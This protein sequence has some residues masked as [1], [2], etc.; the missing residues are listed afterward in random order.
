MAEHFSFFDSV[1]G[2]DG[3]TY[4]RE[5]DAQQFTDY[6]KTL[7]TTGVMKGAG[8]QLVLTANGQNMQTSM[9]T[10]IAFI[11]G[12]YYLNDAPLTFTHD[13]ETLG[14]N[15]IDRIVIRL[16]LNTEARNVKAFIKKGTAS[17]NPVP[18]VLIQN[19][20]VYEI[21][22]AQV[23]IVGGQTYIAA[24]A[25]TD[26]RGKEII[27]PWCGSKI[28][29]NFDNEAL[30]ELINNQLIDTKGL[31][32]VINEFDDKNIDNILKPGLYSG[33]FNS[34]SEVTGTLPFNSK[35]NFLMKVIKYTYNTNSV[36][37][38]VITR[39]YLT[40]LNTQKTQYR[41][42]NS[43]VGSWGNWLE[44]GMQ[45]INDSTATTTFYVDGTNGKDSPD[46]GGS[47]G[48]G[49][50]K[51]IQY[52]INQ[53]KK[54]NVGDVI[55]SVTDAVYNE[56]V[57]LNG[58]SGAKV[59]LKGTVTG[60][61]ANSV[62]VTN[63]DDIELGYLNT[64]KFVSFDNVKRAH[65]V[66]HK[67]TVTGEGSVCLV[68]NNTQCFVDSCTY[69]NSALAIRANLNSSVYVAGCDGSNNTMIYDAKGSVIRRGANTITGATQSTTSEGG[70][71]L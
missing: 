2:E 67:R 12:R 27:C 69:S 36:Q 59:F 58:F 61:T 26:E 45:N 1:I 57:T 17:A 60:F 14:L 46:K 44:D 30:S 64:K 50:F 8:N 63:C 71:V 54:L 40:S 43:T 34:S 48:T 21:S 56:D 55:I 70:Q 6:F 29:P 51:T 37:G 18:P 35:D 25:V 68:C 19:D 5:Y 62:S 28:L 7:V 24:N 49:A 53:V 23:R 31:F 10:G 15:R 66:Y 32:Y 39:Q 22:I 20:T 65:L 13:T 41:I 33:Y 47:A 52:A 9:N 3:V 4:D 16:D 42:Y 11:E 38:I